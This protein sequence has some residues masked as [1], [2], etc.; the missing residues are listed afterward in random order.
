M[1]GQPICGDDDIG[2]FGLWN[3]TI[4]KKTHEKPIFNIK[5]SLRVNWESL[6]PRCIRKLN[7]QILRLNSLDSSDRDRATCFNVRNFFEHFDDFFMWP[8]LKFQ[9]FFIFSFPHFSFLK[10]QSINPLKQTKNLREMSILL[11]RRVHSLPYTR[12]YFNIKC[13][14]NEDLEQ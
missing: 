13:W 6:R 5:N 7:F 4:K 3:E 8:K 11:S 14:R 10:I 9:K 2:E 1:D 12:V